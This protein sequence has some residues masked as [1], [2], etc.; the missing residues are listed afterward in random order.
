MIDIA[1]AYNKYKF[2]GYE[3]LTWLWFT[4][5]NEPEHVASSKQRIRSGHIG[6]RIVLENPK[7]DRREHITTKGDHANFDTAMLSLQQGALVTEIS[8]CL[9]ADDH[10]W[11]FTLKGDNL[12]FTKLK[13]PQTALIETAAD[14]E[15][16]VLEKAYLLEHVLESVDF[17]FRAF[18][19]QRVSGDWQQRFVPRILK[20]V[21]AQK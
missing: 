3:F 20:W 15:G 7:M 14:V 6:S 21:N 5:E 16:A 19:K 1:A 4:L 18:I 9:K 17:L 12:S 11:Q 2:L 13:T 8:L 10:E